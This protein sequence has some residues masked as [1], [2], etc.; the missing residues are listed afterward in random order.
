MMNANVGSAVR[1][2]SAT[3]NEA[4]KLVKAVD[5]S[6]TKVQIL[7][8]IKKAQDHYEAVLRQVREETAGASKL[9]AE[10]KEATSKA[11]EKLHETSRALNELAEKQTAFYTDRN[12]RME[13]LVK[14]EKA[15]D[16]KTRDFD[17][18]MRSEQQ[19]LARQ[20]DESSR[21]LAHIKNQEDKVKT[22]LQNA[23]VHLKSINTVSETLIQRLNDLNSFLRKQE[24]VP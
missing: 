22:L 20:A 3:I 4:I 6:K 14:R 24:S 15:L 11:S 13:T 12:Q 21:R 8:D 7:E 5:G 19:T 9:K 17:A 16:M 23:T 18:R 10:A 1:A 2:S